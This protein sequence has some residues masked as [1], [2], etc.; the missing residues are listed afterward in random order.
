M[1]GCNTVAGLEVA[2]FPDD[3]GI[4]RGTSALLLSDVRLGS[5]ATAG[6]EGATVPLAAAHRNPP[7]DGVPVTEVFIA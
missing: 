3:H 1:R 5:E 6:V 4:A 7:T 2:D